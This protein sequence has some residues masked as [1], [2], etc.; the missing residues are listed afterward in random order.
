MKKLALILAVLMVLPTAAFGMQMMNNSSLDSIT[1]QSGVSIVFDDVEMF[2][3]ID[4]MGYVDTDGFNTQTFIGTNALTQSTNGGALYITDF[5]LDTLKINAIVTGS[6]TSGGTWDLK[7]ATS[8]NID[9]QY[10]YASTATIQKVG[11]Y[12]SGNLKGLENYTSWNPFAAS[13]GSKYAAKALTIDVT[14]DLPVTSEAFQANTGNT[15]V[16]IGGVLIGLPTV[17]ISVSDLVF[18]PTFTDIAGGSYC[19]N[20][21]D[22]YGTIVIQGITAAVL[23]G[24]VE[25]SPY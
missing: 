5:Q 21:N 16:H 9:L 15:A 1:G 24:W 11:S 13:G 17:E 4:K 12:Y 14:A 23:N 18:T 10:D 20:S 22:S 25:I 6:T 3:N 19:F 2:I 8:G 7:S